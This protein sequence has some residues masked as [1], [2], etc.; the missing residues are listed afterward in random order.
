[1]KSES[2]MQKVEIFYMIP[3]YMLKIRSIEKLL[4]L[5]ESKFHFCNDFMFLIS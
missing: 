1:M 5:N 2:D 3:S 4:F